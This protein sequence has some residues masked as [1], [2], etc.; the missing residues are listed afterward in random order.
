MYTDI[1]ECEKNNGACEQI[2]VNSPGSYK[3][4]CNDGYDLFTKDGQSGIF[5]QP[6]EDGTKDD[7]INRFN[8]T[9]IPRMCGNM[10]APDNGA[11][12]AT[13]KVFRHPMIIEFQCKFGHEMMGPSHLQCMADGKWNGSAPLCI[14]TL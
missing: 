6:D 12:L 5:I 1:N 8:K 3:C 4:Q 11:L 14:R 7:D 13:D 2:C 9:C 10:T